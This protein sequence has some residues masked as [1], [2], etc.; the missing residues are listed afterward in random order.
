HIVFII[1]VARKPVTVRA[2]L[3]PEF[4]H[5]GRLA[6]R[7]KY[8]DV[9]V[10]E[11]LHA[12]IADARIGQFAKQFLP[13]AVILPS[14]FDEFLARA[15]SYDPLNLSEDEIALSIEQIGR[16]RQKIIYARLAIFV[17]RQGVVDIVVHTIE[18]KR[19]DRTNPGYR[20]GIL[21]F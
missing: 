15:R 6:I 13:L 18:L 17:R 11:I 20:R 12:R 14:S 5:I 8:A 1:Q 9:G 2:Q 10:D 3:L 19:P 4:K 7:D 21:S 16:I